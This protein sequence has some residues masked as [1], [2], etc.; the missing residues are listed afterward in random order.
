MIPNKIAWI[1]MESPS[2]LLFVYFFVTGTAEK[3]IV[4]WIIFSLYA[5][6]YLNRTFIWPFK[7][8]SKNKQMPLLIFSSAFCFNVVNGFIN[9]Y[10]LGNFAIYTT[11]WLVSLPFVVGFVIFSTGFLINVNSDNR[12]IALRKVGEKGYKIPKGG[13]FEFVSCPNI[14]G[15]I[16]EWIGWAILTWSLPTLSFSIWS[17]A[18]LLPRALDHHRWYKTNF[19]DYPENRK[20]IFPFIL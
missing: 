13:F 1:V 4:S 5:L 10:F 2:L 15:E 20:A 9:G 12:L 11:D 19:E 6:H 18:N 14:M 3:N 8:K 7:I 16:I 17:V